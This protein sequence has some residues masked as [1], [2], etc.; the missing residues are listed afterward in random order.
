[1]VTTFLTAAALLYGA[2]ALPVLLSTAR[3]ECDG[4]SIQGPWRWSEEGMRVID[5]EGRVILHIRPSDATEEEFNAIAAVPELL[6]AC[7]EALAWADNDGLKERLF[8]AICKA[9]GE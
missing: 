8:A 4:M 6:A 3:K 7:E 2:A 5:A 1:M 9:K